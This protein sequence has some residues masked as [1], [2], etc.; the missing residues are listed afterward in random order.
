[1]RPGPPG[2]EVAADGRQFEFDD[3]GSDGTSWRTTRPGR[4]VVRTALERAATADARR[5]LGVPGDR[6]PV[7]AARLPHRRVGHLVDRHVE[8]QAGQPLVQD[9]QLGAQQQAGQRRAETGVDALAEAEM[10][11]LEPAV[12]P[13]VV[14]RVEHRRVAARA[15][16]G[17]EDLSPA[18]SC[19][20]PRTVSRVTRRGMPVI[21]DSNRSSS[22]SAR[23]RLA[24]SC[25]A[26]SYAPSWGSRCARPVQIRLDDVSWPAS[27]R[28]GNSDSISKSVSSTSPA[29][30]TSQTW[31]IR[32]SRRSRFARAITSST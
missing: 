28:P 14:G 10:R 20:P 15:L 18:R 1:M 3:V 8:A 9:P 6:Q 11:L 4:S 24:S 13:E 12:E 21:A 17:E 25:C 22:S 31:L 19:V 32:S 16:V 5:G 23:A 29:S 26:A 27:M 2:R 7:H 30:R